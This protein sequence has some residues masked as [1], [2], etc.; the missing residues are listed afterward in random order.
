MPRAQPVYLRLLCDAGRFLLRDLRRILRRPDE[1]H[2]SAGPE[3]LPERRRRQA[4]ARHRS[5]NRAQSLSSSRPEKSRAGRQSPVNGPAPAKPRLF[6]V[7]LWGLG[8]LLIATPFLRAATEKY[9]VTVLAKPYAT[10]LQ[11]R[12]WPGV[13]VVPFT[14][15]WTAFKHK[16]RLYAWPWR[17]MFR[18]RKQIGG[19]RF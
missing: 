7:E 9:E 2:R 4:R 14:A 17:E 11:A 1:V 10:D 8:D 12:F 16:Y 18:L 6:V 3:C 5:E 15:P 13:K 19:G